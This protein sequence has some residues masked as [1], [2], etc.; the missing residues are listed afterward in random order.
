M[1][2]KRSQLLD[3]NGFDTEIAGTEQL[4]ELI[5]SN[6]HVIEGYRE[7][8]FL[9]AVDKVI[10]QKN[11]QITFRLTNRL[12]LSESRGKEAADDDAKAYTHRV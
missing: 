12:E 10:V 7:D 11:G 2:K 9:Q 4:L 1:K 8:L 3:N 5:R 6:P